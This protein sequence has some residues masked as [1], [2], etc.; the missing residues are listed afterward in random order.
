MPPAALMEQV[1][2]KVVFALE[3]LDPITGLAVTCGIAPSIPGLP[4]AN[5]TP[6][7]RF[8]WRDDGPPQARQVDVALE[9]ANPQYLPPSAALQFNLPANDGT[10]SPATLLR[11]ASLRTTALYQP[12]EGAMAVIGTLREGNGSTTPIADAEITV[13]ISHSGGTGQHQSSHTAITGSNGDFIAVLAGLTDEVPDPEPGAPGAIAGWL[14]VRTPAG[15]K[16]RAIDPPLRPGR[17]TALR[18]PVKWEPDPP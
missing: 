4:P 16:L 9:I 1:S 14:R 15:T 7:H 5:A 6:S 17:T 11:Q 12:P 13:E 18:S 10:A 3:L 8:V 2:R